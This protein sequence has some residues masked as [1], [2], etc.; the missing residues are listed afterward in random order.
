MP[1]KRYVKG[2]GKSCVRCWQ[3]RLQHGSKLKKK[4]F[5]KKFC[6]EIIEKEDN[7]TIKNTTHKHPNT[8]SQ[9]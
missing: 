3:N 9:T 4:F 5:P 1:E 8:Y 6:E 2:C 7:P